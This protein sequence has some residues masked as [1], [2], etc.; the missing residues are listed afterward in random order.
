MSGST[1]R[2]VLDVA[3]FAAGCITEIISACY[4]VV[5]ALVIGARMASILILI[6][7]G[8]WVLAWI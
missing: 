7:Y 3:A 1:F 2:V 6:A 8:C 5:A 4:T